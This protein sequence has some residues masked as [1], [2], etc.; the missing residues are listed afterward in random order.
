MKTVEQI[1]NRDVDK[2]APFYQCKLALQIVKIAQTKYLQ[3]AAVGFALQ[4]DD[5]VTIGARSRNI[6]TTILFGVVILTRLLC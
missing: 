6:T 4:K 5:Q 3:N 1:F 2:E